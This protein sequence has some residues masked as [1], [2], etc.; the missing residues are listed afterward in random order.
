M[1]GARTL[2]GIMEKV[3]VKKPPLAYDGRRNDLTWLQPTLIAEIEYRLTHDGKLRHA[4]Y[5]G[6]GTSKTMRRF[7]DNR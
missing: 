3:T 2:R 7:I 6:Y 1:T 4:S 5:K